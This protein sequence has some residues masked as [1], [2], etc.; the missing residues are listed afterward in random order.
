MKTL[1]EK[2]PREQEHSERVSRISGLIGTSMG[3]TKEEINELKTAGALHDIGKIA[4]G[5]EI[6]DKIAELSDFEWLE[7][8]RHPEISYSILSSLNDYAPAGQYHSCPS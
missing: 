4:I 6:L 1:Y 2:L 3:M 5:N 8:R 7:I